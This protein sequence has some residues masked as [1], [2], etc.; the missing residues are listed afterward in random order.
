MVSLNIWEV[1]KMFN[2]SPEYYINKLKLDS[3]PEGGFYKEVYRSPEIFEQL[4]LRY[5]G[6]RNFSTSIYYL[7]EGH[8]FSAFHR[9]KSDENWHFY[10]GCR[11][12]IYI[13]DKEGQ[14]VIERLGRDL[15]KNEKF[16]V[17][18]S[19]GQWFAAQPAEKTGF[20]LVGC[21]VAP[22]FDFSDF[23][24]GKRDEL[25]QKYTEYSEIIK[26][27]TKKEPSTDGPSS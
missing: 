5:Q 20:S 27:Y 9:I 18:I 25:L 10:D 8:H 12:N 15:G 23:E 17:L 21:T 6:A 13:L 3:H 2:V 22:G 24:L 26:K 11:L 14:L 19:R 1:R 16:Q 4:P 7:L